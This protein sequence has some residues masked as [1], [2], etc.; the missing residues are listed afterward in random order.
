MS[1]GTGLDNKISRR[2]FLKKLGLGASTILLS[3]VLVACDKL[4]PEEMKITYKEVKNGETLPMYIS[5]REKPENV[6]MQNFFPDLDP[7]Q[8][9]QKD[10]KDVAL[11]FKNGAET[12]RMLGEV[13]NPT[14]FKVTGKNPD[15]GEEITVGVYPE[16]TGNLVSTEGRHDLNFSDN[17]YAI[18]VIVAN[19]SYLEDEA[20]AETN[21]GEKYKINAWREVENFGN[22]LVVGTLGQDN[23]FMISGYVC[24]ARALDLK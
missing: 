16:V 2:D 24:D 8:I 4:T 19:Q 23:R 17:L 1:E 6:Y 7:L 12:V 14:L 22:G 3:N 11:P 20:P 15:L 13:T 5:G 21:K 9:R 10:G 18:P